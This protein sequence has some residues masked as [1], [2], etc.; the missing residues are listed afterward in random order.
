MK[1]LIKPSMYSGGFLNKIDI[2][3]WEFLEELVK[4]LCN[5][6]PQGRRA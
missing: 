1:D 3:A 2:K 6:R 4:K 5:G